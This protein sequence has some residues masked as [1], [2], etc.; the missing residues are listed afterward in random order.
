MMLVR[1][2]LHNTTLYTKDQWTNFTVKNRSKIG[3]NISIKNALFC[4]IKLQNK[5]HEI[6]SQL[7]YFKIL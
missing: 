1:H 5:L 7:N 2:N 4:G 3:V 6:N